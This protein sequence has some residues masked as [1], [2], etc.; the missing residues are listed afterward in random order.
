MSL[1]SRYRN[2]ARK[3]QLSKLNLKDLKKY[4]VNVR[5]Q[6][7]ALEHEKKL[8][9]KIIQDER[10]VKELQRPE[11]QKVGREF[12]GNVGKGISNKVGTSLQKARENNK[13]YSGGYNNVFTQGGS[14]E[15]INPFT[16]LP[17]K[18]KK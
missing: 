10:E 13:N 15:R 3:K 1:I 4:S 2:A 11:Y 7:E 16:G 17:E 9:D 6:K 18:R 5:K 12:L 8:K 14:G